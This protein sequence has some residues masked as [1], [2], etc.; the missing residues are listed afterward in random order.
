MHSPLKMTAVRGNVVF[1]GTDATVWFVV[2]GVRWAFRD[3]ASRTAQIE[4][5]AQRYAELTGRTIHIRVTNRP[6]SAEGW[7]S[8]MDSAALAPLPSWPA[9]LDAEA[10]HLSKLALSDKSVFLGVDVSRPLAGVARYL[11]Q[12]A[13]PRE[14]AKL[15]EQ[16]DE[17]TRIVAGDGL[18]ARPCTRT[19]LAW[20]ID[21]SVALGCPSPAE[22]PDFGVDWEKDDIAE[23]SD[24]AEWAMP[25]RYG[26]TVVIEAEVGGE[27]V[28]RHV[29]TVTM[30][31][32]G[33][34]DPNSPWL[35]ALDTLGFPVEVALT[36]A[37]QVPDVTKKRVEQSISRN[38][39]Q[40]DHY[41]DFRRRPPKKL[42]R[43]IEHGLTIQD[44]VDN[45]MS[46][47]STRAYM[48]V[49]MSMSGDTEQEGR[50][51]ARQVVAKYAKKIT[52]ERT[53]DQHALAREMIPGEPLSTTAF[54]REPPVTYLAGAMPQVT[55][56]VGHETGMYLGYTSQGSAQ[57]PALWDLHRSTEIRERSGLTLVSGTLG[58]GKSALLFMV[59]Y[60]AAL[61][62]I[63]TVILDPSGPLSRLCDLPEL[64][65]A[66][67]SIDLLQAKPGTLSP[68]RVIPEPLREHY[69][70]KE[71][72]LH[73]L[74]MAE[75]S[76]RRL[77]YDVLKQLL[78]PATV[79]DAKT[80]GVLRAAIKRVGG[81]VT[82]TARQVVYALRHETGELADHANRVADELED[83]ADMPAAQLIMPTGMSID[84]DG[85]KDNAA[86]TVISMKGL[87]LPRE[88]SDRREW[89]TD[90]SMSTVLLHLAGW[91]VQRS[92]YV[93]Q[94]MQARK[95]IIV[96]EGHALTRIASGRLL[97]STSARDS[98][99]YN[100]RAIFA[101][102]S[103][104]DILGA[105][106]SN[107][108]DSVFALRT[109]D[110]AAQ[111][112]SLRVMGVATGVG[113]EHALSTLS[114]HARGA[115]NRSMAREAVW[116]DGEGAVERFTVDLS[117]LPAHAREALDTT[118]RP[119]VAA[120]ERPVRVA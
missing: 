66:S 41:L 112:A 32:M 115:T 116:A 3:D 80:G 13:A 59:A 83:I 110:L 109:D 67:S 4:A 111:Q 21:R 1:V 44:D 95:L 97:L 87:T 65:A 60:K 98:R 38:G 68:F 56:H 91:L 84:A 55:H 48:W 27:R 16:L 18:N 50:E 106:V 29:C 62:G 40:K 52:V 24:R 45:G 92:V 61:A 88:G 31:R 113:Y 64:K 6:W 89:S 7:R 77:C 114:S 23:F 99:K 54:R 94:D 25:R 15:A 79:D 90:E 85:S 42:D 8:S 9:H 78:E 14:D 34:L 69:G 58:A 93:Q 108:V 120:E 101:S 71:E 19:E 36:A 30:G 103:V 73:A 74:S 119:Q 70:P 5:V 76:R 82:S 46:G 105:N 72:W 37:I 43:A 17:I 28:T 107:L 22:R 39:H 51:L 75:A 2:P 10:A 20:L 47:L 35:A 53:F 57:R 49:R 81:H 11:G 102:H 117:S 26:P 118:A 96:D 100:T 86:L 63:H 104:E 33:P 12:F